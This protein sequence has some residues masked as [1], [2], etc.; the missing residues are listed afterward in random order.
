MSS[1]ESA[2]PDRVTRA[3]VE[4]LSR[5]G[6]LRAIGIGAGGV[7]A[8]LAG[9]EGGGFR[10]LYGS[11][12]S[13]VKTQDK[14]AQTQLSTI[15]GRTGQR[16]RNELTFK[17][18]GGEAPQT[19]RYRLEVAVKESVTT[20]LVTLDGTSGGQIYQIDAKFQL[21]DIAEKKVLLE[22]FAQTRATSERFTNVF[23][24]VRAGEDAQER[25][26]K[27]MATELKARIAAFLGANPV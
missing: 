17:F 13:D 12:G 10:P 20:T 1:S 21:L 18:Y 7:G 15:P 25:A 14:L 4:G 16:I 27:A 6:F 24:N 2:R 5:R 9:C 8:G 22:G 26:S 19:P 23:S 3:R 11:L